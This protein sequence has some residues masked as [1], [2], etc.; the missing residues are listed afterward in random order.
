MNIK[1]L[2]QIFDNIAK[3]N[4]IEIEYISLPCQNIKFYGL[5]NIPN[6]IKINNFFSNDIQIETE[7]HEVVHYFDVYHKD[8]L[9]RETIAD[10]TTI[11]IFKH[12]DIPV[13]TYTNNQINSIY[14]SFKT[15]IDNNAYNR[16]YSIIFY[17]ID[18]IVKNLKNIF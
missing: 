10:Y 9:L 5:F 7:V 4:G 17:E 11:Q 15:I 14:E 6:K 8:K 2:K 18:F 3:N 12:F 1:N 16:I 13:L